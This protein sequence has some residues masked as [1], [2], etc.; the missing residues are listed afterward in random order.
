MR[1]TKVI[2]GMKRLQYSSEKYVPPSQSHQSPPHM[3]F[4]R[5]GLVYLE[6]SSHVSG[7][8]LIHIKEPDSALYSSEHRVLGFSGPVSRVTPS[9]STESTVGSAHKIF[10]SR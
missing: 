3:S 8:T 2:L 7:L 10:V 6:P 5:Q 4:P 1:I 9:R